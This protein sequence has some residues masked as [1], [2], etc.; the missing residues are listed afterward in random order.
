MDSSA[1]QLVGV[2]QRRTIRD[3]EQFVKVVQVLHTRMGPNWKVV[4]TAARSQQLGQPVS[5]QQDT[6]KHVQV[7]CGNSSLG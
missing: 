4:Q 3:R 1:R 6:K 7:A 2:K 5:L